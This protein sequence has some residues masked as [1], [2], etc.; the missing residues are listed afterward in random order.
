VVLVSLAGS[1]AAQE[2]RAT[3]TGRVVDEQGGALPG[4]TVTTT[5]V[6]TNTTSQA[7]TDTDGTYTF[8][9]LPPGVYTV[10]AELSG[11]QRLLR[12]DVNLGAGQRV[13]VDLAL[14]IG[15][16]AETVNVTAES[17]LLQT[18]SA[19]TGLSVQIGQINN[20]PMSGRAPSSL[21]KL[22]AGVS[23]LTNPTANTRPFDN[24]GTSSFAVAG[25]QTRTSDL[26]LDGGPNMAR[27]RRISYNPPADIVQEVTIETFQSDAAFG[28]TASGTVNIVTKSG[29]NALRGSAGFYTQPSDLAG[30]NYFTKRSGGQDPPYTYNQGGFT[31]GGPVVIPGVIDGRNRV[32][33]IVSYDNIRNR[34]P[35]PTLATVPTER[36]RR[37]DFSELLPLGDIYRIYDPMTGV[38]EGN[39]RRRQP[40]ENNVIPPHRINPIAQAYLGYFP[41]PN[42]PGEVNGQANYL[43]PNAR[44]DTYYSLMGR[45]DVNFTPSSRM[46]V[47]LYGNDR[48]ERK[49]NLFGNQGTGAI[50]PRLNSGAM[51][52]YVHTVRPTMVLN[53]RVGWTRFS[54]HEHR[55]STGFDFASLGFPTGLAAISLQPV[56][57]LVTFGDSTTSLGPTGGNRA[58]AGFDEVFDSVQWFT[59]LTMVRGSQSIKMGADLRFLREVSID[60]GDS[61]GT[62]SF[63]TNWTRGPLDNA[64][65]APHGQALAAFLLGLPTGG[66][67][68]VE[69]R[70]DVRSSS[71]AFF[72]Q[73]DWRVNGELTVNLGLRYEYEQGTTEANDGLVVGFDPDAENRVTAAAK[74]AYAANPHPDLPV[75]QFNPTGGL[76][77]ASA[78]RRQI[79]DTPKNQFSPRLGVAYTPRRLGGQTVFRGGFGIFY[80]TNGIVGVQRPGFSQTTPLVA[81]NDGFLT[82]YATLSNP[83]P[84][85]VLEPVGSSLGVNQNLGQS[86]TFYN[87]SLQPN[88]S[89]RYTAG[90]QQGLGAGMVFELAY[91]YNQARGL[92]INEGLNYTPAEFLSTSDTRDQATIN[93]L[94]ANVPNPFAGLLPGTTLNGATIQLQQLL[95]RHPQFTGVTLSGANIGYSNQ[96]TLSLTVQ[97]RFSAGTQL[98]AT[99][100]R[101]RMKEATSRLNPSDAELYYGRANEDRPNRLVVSG[102]YALP[103]GGD[104]AIGSGAPTWARAIISDWTV[105]GMYTYQSGSP[106]NWGNVIYLGGDL[107]WDPRNID[108]AFDVTRF[109]RTS[110]QQ[111]SHNI[112]TLPPDFGNLYLNPI[113]T[114]NVAVFKD[115]RLG[116]GQ[117]VQ[118]RA[119]AFN[120]FDRVQFGGPQMNPTNANF[121]RITSQANSPRTFQFAVRW[122][123]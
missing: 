106:V 48:V 108:Q 10:A 74:A 3:L 53:T 121:G 5:H 115:I 103:F 28:N 43:S 82:P 47:K 110:A 68:D 97:K 44:T 49:G 58:G 61:A 15:S 36:M 71:G 75:N 117:Q 100:T 96:H 24:A 70:A 22:S 26:L 19:S 67:F 66:A 37:G 45:V 85:G 81:T 105:S 119:E 39:R 69:T 72:I 46:M 83:F 92:T 21:V 27:D 20:L 62:Y 65:A 79:F 1:A 29:T 84:D 8:P 50:L 7:V 93:R 99:Y 35:G 120:A 14:R 41:L 113:S 60:Y 6:E 31:A 118:I 54:D 78:A 101:S 102:V 57:P 42:I 34:Y 123:K 63:G 59:S 33:W 77:F 95:T 111:L 38:A 2:Y 104:A 23:D 109:N 52:D 30:T 4:V 88:Y 80:H 76:I 18:A 98:L 73:D 16:V 51:V 90:L 112:R 17:S 116:G 56:L 86:V 94:T 25:G 114:L 64:A 32:F 9:L 87:P 89:R 55:E 12:S 11:F 40:F 107:S 122:T 13:A 91:Q